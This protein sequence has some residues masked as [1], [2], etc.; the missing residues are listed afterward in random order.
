MNYKRNYIL[1]FNIF[2]IFYSIILLFNNKLLAYFPIVGILLSVAAIINVI[3]TIQYVNE[4]KKQ[5]CNCSESVIR[6]LMYVLAIINAV[7]WALTVLILIF[8]LFHYSKYGNKKMTMSTKEMKK[9]LNDIKKNNINKI[10]K[11]KK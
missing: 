5:N 3:F 11:I 2:L 9:I 6:T 7:T 1:C 8:V 10:N 4:L